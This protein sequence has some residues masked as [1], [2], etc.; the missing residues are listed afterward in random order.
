MVEKKKKPRR[1]H[2]RP[3]LR[4]LAPHAA[5]CQGNKNQVR[6][7]LKY[8]HAHR[9]PGSH[10]F[11]RAASCNRTEMP[12]VTVALCI[13]NDH[14]CYRTAAQKGAKPQKT[15]VIEDLKAPN[16]E[17]T[18][19]KRSKPVEIKTILTRKSVSHTNH[20]VG[21]NVAIALQ[22]SFNNSRIGAAGGR[23]IRR[24]D[25]LLLKFSRRGQP[26]TESTA[27]RKD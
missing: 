11:L 22:T 16:R 6:S 8:V 2:S 15:E 24:L 13:I 10:V 9:L 21:Q 26:Q 18:D 23:R 1:L 3:A 4:Q 17:K 25:A 12:I 20:N 27:S 19:Q 7:V 14:H 5:G